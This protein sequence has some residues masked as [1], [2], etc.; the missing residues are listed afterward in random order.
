MTKLVESCREQHQRHHDEKEARHKEN[1]ANP[2]VDAMDEVEPDVRDNDDEKKWY[3]EVR[4]KQVPQNARDRIDLTG[5][6]DV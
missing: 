2:T 1:F 4:R 6:H 3:E 5:T